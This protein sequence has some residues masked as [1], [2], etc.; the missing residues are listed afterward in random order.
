MTLHDELPGD[1]LPGDTIVKQSFSNVF[2][3]DHSGEAVQGAEQYSPCPASPSNAQPEAEMG[4]VKVT[5]PEK[6]GPG[7]KLVFT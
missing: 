3:L 5:W 6:T 7:F 4:E 1:E 2:A